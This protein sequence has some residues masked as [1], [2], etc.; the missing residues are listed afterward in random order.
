MKLPIIFSLLIIVPIFEARCPNSLEY[1]CLPGLDSIGIGFD[2][3]KGKSFG[4]G[5][6]VV[7][8]TY[9]ANH[10]HIFSMPFGDIAKYVYPD[11]VNVKLQTEQFLGHKIFHSVNEYV[12]EQSINANVN[13]HV[14]GFFS[15]SVDTNYAYSVMKDGMHIMAESRCEVGLYSITLSPS[16][17]LHTSNEFDQFVSQLPTEYDPDAYRKFIEEYGTHYISASVFGGMAKMR[18]AI[19]QGYYSEHSDVSIETQLRISWG[20]YGGGGGGG[21]SSKTHDSYWNSHADSYTFT[22]GG[23]PAIKS[24]S[25]EEEWVKWVKSVQ[26]G[27]PT[28]SSY[29]LSFIYDLLPEGP[30]RR[31]LK[32]AVEQYAT[33]HSKS[34]PRANLAEYRMSWCDCYYQPLD[35]TFVPYGR[36]STFGC[37]RDGHMMVEFINLW[38]HK[39]DYSVWFNSCPHSDNSDLTKVYCCRPCFK[40]SN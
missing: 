34:F 15:A 4:V 5:R 33:D 25:S 20:M 10:T 8:I 32:K 39:H 16:N 38:K 21:T 26:N 19:A 27:A 12:T 35:Q 28:V 31:M 29:S 1:P 13:A 6:N 7:N 40:I 11:Q 9:L 14:G 24:F 18:T 17:I 3:V 37:K 23:D 2:A 36:W 30:R 22:E